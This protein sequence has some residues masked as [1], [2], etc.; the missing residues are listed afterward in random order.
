MAWGHGG[1]QGLIPGH[2]VVPVQP[3]PPLKPGAHSTLQKDSPSFLPLS[4]GKSQEVA[5]GDPTDGHSKRPLNRVASH[6][7][8]SLLFPKEGSLLLRDRADKSGSPCLT[9]HAGLVPRPVPPQAWGAPVTHP[10]RHVFPFTLHLAHKAALVDK[11]PVKMAVS[12]AIPSLN[13]SRWRTKDHAPQAAVC[14]GAALCHCCPRASLPVLLPE[15][16][17]RALRPGGT[18]GQSSWNPVTMAQALSCRRPG[19]LLTVFTALE[20]GDGGLSQPPTSLQLLTSVQCVYVCV[21]MCVLVCLR[22]WHMCVHT[23]V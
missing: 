2:T 6:P 21:C 3:R 22:L 15:E 17:P 12:V 11:Q 13:P 10:T 8:G 9:P 16:S 19:W 23:C 20:L 4:A 18:T 1:G 7:P 14:T 5:L